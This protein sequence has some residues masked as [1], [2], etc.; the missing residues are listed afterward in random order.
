MLYYTIVLYTYIYIYIC[1]SL[2]FRYPRFEAPDPE[3]IGE[4]AAGGALVAA[5]GF[6]PRELIHTCICIYIYMYIYIYI[7]TY[8]YIYIYIYIYIHTYIHVYIYI[9]IYWLLLLIVLPPPATRSERAGGFL[10]GRDSRGPP[11]I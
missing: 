10:A 11:I 3:R 2:L 5:L 9:Y 4:R 7:H 1:F 8:V 6:A